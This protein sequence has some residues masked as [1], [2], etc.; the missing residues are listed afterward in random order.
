MWLSYCLQ[1]RRTTH[2]AGI[3]D[4]SRATRRRHLERLFKD[5][6]SW[7]NAYEIE[8]LLC[9][10]LTEEQLV[11]ELKRRLSEARALKL[12]HVEAINEE[13]NKSIGTSDK[14]FLLHG[15]L[16]DLQWFYSK[17]DQRRTSSQQLILRVSSIGASS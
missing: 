12:E 16:N 4:G 11:I 6:R 2:P 3:F 14:R 8:Q 15:L 13:I 17:R 1:Q 10:V 5:G 9:F 7:R